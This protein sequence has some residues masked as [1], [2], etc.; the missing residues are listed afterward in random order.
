M[1]LSFQETCSHWINRILSMKNDHVSWQFGKFM[2]SFAWRN[3]NIYTFGL[4]ERRQ[5]RASSSHI[6]F[7]SNFSPEFCLLLLNTKWLR[8][9]SGQLRISI[10]IKACICH[11]PSGRRRRVRVRWVGREYLW[12]KLRCWWCSADRWLKWRWS[13]GSHVQTDHCHTA[14]STAVT[15]WVYLSGKHFWSIWCRIIM[16]H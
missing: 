9:C 15:V 12:A 10:N 3:I 7:F 13:C 8:V 5:T 1:L 2:H 6:I 11:I 14:R 16:V 4:Q